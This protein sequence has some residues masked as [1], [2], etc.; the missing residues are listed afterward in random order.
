MNG[1]STSRSACVDDRDVDGVRDDAAVERGGD[2]LGDDH[3]RAVLRL[4][5]SRRRGAA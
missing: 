4:A 2:L 3:A 1:P 5:R